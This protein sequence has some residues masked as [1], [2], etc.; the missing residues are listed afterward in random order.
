M[1]DYR[2][3]SKTQDSG[4]EQ[5]PISEDP[6]EI[7]ELLNKKK[8]KEVSNKETSKDEGLTFPP[9]FTPN[10]IDDTVDGQVYGSNKF[11]NTDS[12][13]TKDSIS[14]P[15]VRLCEAITNSDSEFVLKTI[16]AQLLVCTDTLSSPLVGFSGGLLCVWD[17]NTFSKESVTI[18]DS[19]L[20]IRGTWISSSMKLLIVSVYAPQDLSRKKSLWEHIYDHRPILMREL[21]VDYGPS[22][23]R[24]FHSWFSKDGFDKFVEAWCKE[25]N[26]RSN[27]AR[28]SIQ[29]RVTEIDKLLVK[30]K[31]NEGLVSERTSLLKD[32]HDIN[33]CYSLD[34]AQKAKIRWSI[35]GDENSKYFHG[36]INKKRSQLAIRGVLV[37]GDWIDEPYKVKSEFF[38]HFMNHFSKHSGPKISSGHQMFKQLSDKQKE[39]LES[40]VTYEEI[41]KAVWD[42][43]T[44]KSPGPDGFTFDFIR[45]YWKTM[46]QDVVNDVHEF[47]N[48]SK[49]LLD[50][51][52]LLLLLFPKSQTL[53]L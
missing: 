10:V 11:P 47:F 29:S 46:D 8:D 38:N 9:G 41:K 26:Q 37:D 52:L 27:A 49:F 5:K 4:N 34:L 16:L 35:E 21:V 13:T 1:N 15:N 43:G 6:F 19:F 24:V 20:A 28:S 7:Y 32:F 25:D 45:R 22:P 53:R 23:F 2:M 50:V 40:N 48:S 44:N 17:P 39:I 33:A 31:G 12:H 42:C 18:S 36:I 30:G 3:K 14:G 51:T